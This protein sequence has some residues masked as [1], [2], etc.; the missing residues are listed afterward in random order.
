MAVSADALHI[1]VVILS[2]VYVGGIVGVIVDGGSVKN[3]SH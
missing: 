2:F 1:A 3:T